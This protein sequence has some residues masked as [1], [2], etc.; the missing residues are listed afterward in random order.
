MGVLNPRLKSRHLS[1]Q[2]SLGNPNVFPG[3]EGMYCRNYLP[4]SGSALGFPSSW[5]CWE[6]CRRKQPER[7]PI[8]FLDHLRLLTPMK[9]S[10]PI[11]PA[12]VLVGSCSFS[13][14]SNF[15][16]NLHENQN[17]EGPV[18][19]SFSFQLSCLHHD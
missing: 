15:S 8:R 7:I 13:N 4:C 18:T 16:R 12:H 2:F 6:T 1:V 17:G 10:Q 11:S 5:T 19:W 3:T 9:R 14:K